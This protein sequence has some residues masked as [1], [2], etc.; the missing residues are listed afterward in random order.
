MSYFWRLKSAP[1]FTTTWCLLVHTWKQHVLCHCIFCVNLHTPLTQDIQLS[2]RSYQQNS[3]DS[4][5]TLCCVGKCSEWSCMDDVFIHTSLV[6][7]IDH[8]KDIVFFTQHSPF[9]C[10]ES[11][12]LHTFL[13]NIV[14]FACAGIA[15]NFPNNWVHVIHVRLYM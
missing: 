7:V 13:V 5:H 4:A 15:L 2:T 6:N 1:A 14:S 9:G 3:S 11:E 12:V 10:N 8:N